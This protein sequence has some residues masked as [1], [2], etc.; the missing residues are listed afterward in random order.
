M[1]E[2]DLFSLQKRRLRR[3]VIV[4]FLRLKGQGEDDRLLSMFIESKRRNNVL[5][6]ARW[7]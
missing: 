3:D 1:K 4:I 6:E 5:I 7:I 2:L